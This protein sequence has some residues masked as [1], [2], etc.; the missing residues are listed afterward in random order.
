M[1]YIE[2]DIYQIHCKKFSIMLGSSC[3]DHI[4][5]NYGYD[6]SAFNVSVWAGQQGNWVE[7]TVRGIQ[8]ARYFSNSL[9]A[10]SANGN[11]FSSPNSMFW[12]NMHNILSLKLRHYVGRPAKHDA[13]N[14]VEETLYQRN[15][16][17]FLAESI[18]M[19]L[20]KS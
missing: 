10:T 1:E 2:T 14:A 19:V 12:I 20:R 17:S 13:E 15:V 5:E 6:I 4:S 7:K 16:A 8:N 3:G 11:I 9:M 18:E